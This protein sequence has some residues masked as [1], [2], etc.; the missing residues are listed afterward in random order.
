M[1]A[2]F[3]KLFY[4]IKNTLLNSADLKRLVFYNTADAL[5]RAEPSYSEAEPSIYIKPIIYIYQDSP[6]IGISSF[7]SI[8][9]IEAIIL[10]GSIRSSIKVSIACDRQ[11]WELNDY[12][13]R[14]L[15]ILSEV[16]DLLDNMKSEIAGRLTLRVVKEVYFNNEIV[17]YTALF[18]IDEEKGDVIYE[19]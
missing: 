13:I 15:A 19:F 5:T 10:D 16:S 6:E 1:F 11:V 9:L 3:E 4:Q 2:N 18:D 8:G 7:I 17:G 14:P 12:R